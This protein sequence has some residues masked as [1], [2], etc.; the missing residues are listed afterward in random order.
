MGLKAGRPTGRT[1]KHVS[2]MNNQLDSEARLTILLPNA[3]KKQ[4][5][6]Y[7]IENDTDI[8]KVVREAIS[9]IIDND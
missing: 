3:M 4:L 6:L 2:D 9:K 7:A 8:S 1:K 5:K